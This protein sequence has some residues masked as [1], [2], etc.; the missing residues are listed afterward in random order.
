MSDLEQNHTKSKNT[1]LA[2]FEMPWFGKLNFASVGRVAKAMQ[3]SPEP[4]SQGTWELMSAPQRILGKKTKWR[5]NVP[6]CST[7]KT[8]VLQQKKRSDSA[9]TVKIRYDL[10][11][12]AYRAERGLRRRSTMLFAASGWV[13]FLAGLRMGRGTQSRHHWSHQEVSATM[14]LTIRIIPVLQGAIIFERSW[15]AAYLYAH[16]YQDWHNLADTLR[17][18][19]LYLG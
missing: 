14:I 15:G 9:K 8:A 12:K 6:T 19:C 16:H 4:L 7:K 17:Q 13:S 18:W 5:S 1:Y 10:N 11:Y 3:P 2:R